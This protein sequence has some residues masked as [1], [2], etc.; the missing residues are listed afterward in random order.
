MAENELIKEIEKAKEKYSQYIHEEEEKENFIKLMEK[1]VKD[2]KRHEKIM[3]R[4]DKRQK[5]EYDELQK[6]LEEVEK[7]QKAQKKLIDSF[8]KIIAEAIDTKSSYT[9]K[10]CERVP[11]IAI[12]LAKAA[13]QSEKFEFEIKNEQQETEISIAAWLHDCGKIV[14]PEYVV[15]KAVKLETIY[16]RI[17]EIRTRFEVINRD[18]IIEALKRKMN[19]ED[20]KKVDEW[21]KK[22]QKQLQDDFDFIAKLNVGSESIEE[23]TLERLQNIANREWLRYFD[24][25][26]GLSKG[27]I[28]RIPEEDFNQKL[29]VREKLIS[30][31]QRHKIKRPAEEI[32]EYKKY[33]FKVEIPENLYN[34]GEV[35]NLSIKKGT[36]TKEEFFKI[37]EHAMMTIKMLEQLPF[38][39]YL[40]NVP[41]YAGAHHE[42]LNGKGYPRKLTEKDLPIP[43]RIMAIADI[44]E[45]LTASDRPYKH[46]KKL[47]E[48]IDILADMV[49]KGELDKDLFLLF[50]TSGIY[51]EYAKKYLKPEQIDDV[52][53]NAYV[54]YFTK[55]NKTN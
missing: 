41:I 40:K 47:S 8:I 39:D 7:L 32:E 15:D 30:D 11:E 29:P 25:T 23:S 10:H 54:D 9:G 21:L 28:E 43:A 18:L 27:E 42:K 35:Y 14:T 1:F 20:E 52:D 16:N 51:L 50:L 17:H 38:P 6:R 4:S 24:D 19:G 3:L 5:K 33:G 22:E 34:Y 55:G 31:K 45:A 53:V 12:E 36:L 49:K 46:P 2:L 48:A 37:Q 26:K 44:F 13:S